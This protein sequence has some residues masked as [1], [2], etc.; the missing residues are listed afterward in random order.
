ME[1]LWRSWG[2]RVADRAEARGIS[3]REL[4]RRVGITQSGIQQIRHGKVSPRDNTR[5]RIATELDTTVEALF[6]YPSPKKGGRSGAAVH[7]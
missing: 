6:P 1:E 4:A 3:L 7:G 5:L 2:E